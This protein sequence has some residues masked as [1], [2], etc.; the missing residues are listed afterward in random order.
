MRNFLKIY[1]DRL[2]DGQT[3]KIEETV[4][5]EMIDVN[6]TDLQFKQPVFLSGKAYLAEDHLIIQLKIKTEAE[7]PCLICNEQIQKKIV[8]SSFYHTE[9]VANIKGHIYDYTGPMREA[10]LLEVPSYVEC[11]GNCP[12]RTELKNYLDK[13]ETQFPFA[14]LN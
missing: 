9:E 13:G 11:M 10:I 8:I 14:D 2:G 7:M 12:K 5:P 3:E 1:I 4:P 6:E